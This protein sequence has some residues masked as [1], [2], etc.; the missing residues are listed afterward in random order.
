MGQVL[1]TLRREGLAG[2]TLVFFTSDNGPWL[3][4]GEAGG[5]AGLLREGKG[6]TW[7]GGMREPGIAWSPGRVPAGRVTHE[8]ACTMDLFA[9]FLKLSGGELPK[10]RII[11]GLDIRPLLL[12]TGPSPR[13]VF[14]YYRGTQLY[15]ARK[16]RTGP[17][18]HP[19][20]LW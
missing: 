18:H 17:L 20:R 11:D 3:I 16:A 15:A 1:D 8:L 5:S 10:D 2:N 12:G 7:E 6:S 14:F 4:Q 9:T 13:N 19:S